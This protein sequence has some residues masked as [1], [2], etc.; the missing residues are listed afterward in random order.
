MILLAVNHHYVA[1]EAPESPRAIFPTTVAE[2]EREV[3]LLA[4]VFEFVSRDELLAAARGDAE[5]PRRSCAI[6][7]DDGLRCQY[8]VA[9]PALDRLGVPATFFV[10][11]LPLAE[12]RALAV[13]RIHELR[14]RLGDEELL[15]RVGAEAVDER[16]ARAM[17]RYDTAASARV[18]Y[19]LNIALEPAER[20]RLL[21]ELLG[22]D[23]A[24]AERLYLTREQV[25]DLEARG[26]LGA[27]SHAHLPLSRLGPDELRRD[28]QQNAEVLERIAGRRPR[29]ISYPYGTPDAV[30]PQ[31]AAAAAA[32][33]FE[34]GFTMEPALNRSLEQPLLLARIDVNDA[35]GGRH[36]KLDVVDGDLRL[37]D[38]LAPARTRYM[39][40]KAV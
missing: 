19:L 13:H 9:L 17:Y 31:V 14:Q 23:P 16:Q 40:E 6:T 26:L 25:A 21:D 4:R 24:F 38:D 2:L 28:L 15:A 5:L 11:S 35:P 1:D 32:A 18:K 7:F 3:E 29:A 8:E 36:A 22:D 39:S 27:H 10:P 33:G 34:V 12:G 20:D 37:R 30:T